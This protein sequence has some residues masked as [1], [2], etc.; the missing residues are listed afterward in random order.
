MFNHVTLV[1]RLVKD[2]EVRATTNNQVCNFTLA[3]DR[4]KKDQGADFLDC[5]AWGKLS[6]ICGKYLNK[7]SLVLVSGRL[8]TNIYEN[9]DGV[10]IK[11][12]KIMV[13]EMKMLGSKKK[14]DPN[15]INPHNLPDDDSEVPF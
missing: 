8:S 9:K 10:K 4:F 12:V 1:G 6:E 13:A 15:S 5:S 2:P 14:E 11:Q 3:V 7:G